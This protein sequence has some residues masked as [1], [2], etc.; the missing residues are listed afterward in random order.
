M[1]ATP[2]SCGVF[3]D[4]KSA[5]SERK[6]IFGLLLERDARSPDG[7]A[8]DGSRLYMYT[9]PDGLRWTLH[10]RK[11]FPFDPDT[12]NMALYDDRTGK[13]LAYVRTWNPLRRVGVVEIDDMMQPWPYDKGVPP[14]QAEGLPGPVN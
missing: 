3:I 8:P 10:P 4:T 5:P 1:Q 12:L 14:R 9:S 2:E 7:E 11:V 13:Y 6:K